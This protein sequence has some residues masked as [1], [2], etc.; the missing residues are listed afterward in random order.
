[1]QYNRA[2]EYMQE[3]KVKEV[4]SPCSKLH[5]DR[6]VFLMQALKLQEAFFEAGYLAFE[7]KSAFTHFEAS[8]TLQSSTSQSW[9]CLLA[10]EKVSSKT[11][12]L[13]KA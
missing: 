13:H 10:A 7:K 5:D 8:L 9:F 12:D 4:C 1:M 3:K 2:N 11:R 6:R